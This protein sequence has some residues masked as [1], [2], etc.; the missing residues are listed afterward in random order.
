MKKRFNIVDAI[1]VLLI[2]AAVAVCLMFLRSRESAGGAQSTK[3]HFTV[4]LRRVS[5]EM[6][7][8][9][10]TAGIGSNVYRS[11]DG[12]YLGTLESFTYTAQA[13][14]EFAAVSGEYAQYEVPDRYQLYLNVVGDGALSATDISVNGIAVKIGQE[15]YVKGKGYAGGGYVVGVDVDGE[16]EN[17]SVGVGDKELIYS[18]RFDDVRQFTAEALQVGDRLYDNVTNANLGMI[19]DIRVVPFEET[20]MDGSGN[21]VLVV[22]P[23]KYSIFV[24]LSARCTETDNSYF[25]DGKNELKVGAKLLAKSKKIVCEFTYN[26][27]IEVREG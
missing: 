3:V 9:V 15:I 13:E 6:I 1:L 27:L 2:V 17:T 12:Q 26:E 25:I 11:T 24:T 18:V 7:D 19:T 5:R 16:V 10:E 14:T 22:K 21:A 23:E 20:K 4:E 8:C